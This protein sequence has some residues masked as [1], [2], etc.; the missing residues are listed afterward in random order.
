ML[1][2][3]S[4]SYELLDHTADLSIRVTGRS[5]GEFLRNASL[6][7][8]EQIA[9]TDRVEPS[10]KEVI[11]ATGETKEEILVRLLN[12]ILYLHETGKLVFKDIRVEVSNENKAAAELWGEKYDFAKHELALEIKAV[13]YHGLKIEM[14]NDKF[15]A[16][17][18]FDI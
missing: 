5:F 15:T 11:E 18:V 13:T 12:E 17:I 10:V 1:E 9:D 4:M 6:A 2:F 16:D 8:T 14:V 7:M 3:N